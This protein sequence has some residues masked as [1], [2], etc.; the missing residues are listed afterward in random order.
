MNINK[1][2]ENKFTSSIIYQYVFLDKKYPEIIGAT[3]W[4]PNTTDILFLLKIF[5]LL[6]I[7]KIVI[8]NISKKNIYFLNLSKN[9]L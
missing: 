7:I 2:F 3:L 9:F 8:K 1:I 5:F 4:I 6:K